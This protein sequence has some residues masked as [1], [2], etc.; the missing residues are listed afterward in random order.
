MRRK[1]VF[2]IFILPFFAAVHIY[3]LERN[4]ASPLGSVRDSHK[5]W[6]SDIR[7]RLFDCIMPL[8]SGYILLTDISPWSTLEMYRTDPP[9]SIRVH[10]F[11]PLDPSRVEL[12]SEVKVGNLTVQRVRGRKEYFSSTPVVSYIHDGQTALVITGPDQERAETMARA[13]LENPVPH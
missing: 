13:C 8:P 1:V 7:V 11:K 4:T 2:A 5:E 10:E 3:A 6:K 12:I 9:G